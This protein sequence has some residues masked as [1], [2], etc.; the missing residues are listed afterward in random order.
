M[1]K[2]ISLL[3]AAAWA[4]NLFGI[5]TPA[6]AQGAFT[7]VPD[8][9]GMAKA[10]AEEALNDRGL[11]ASFTYWF[12]D[13]VPA[14]QVTSQNPESGTRVVRGS[15][16]NLIVS[17]PPLPPPPPPPVNF[18][19]PDLKAAVEAELGVTDPTADD[20]LDLVSLYADDSNIDDL[21]PHFINSSTM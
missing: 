20:M 12:T 7:Y 10:D 11:V 18:A 19:D 15:T 21:V 14:G 16:V 8:V 3:L 13:T 5:V 2:R 17:A 1:S 4:V 9:V 6:M